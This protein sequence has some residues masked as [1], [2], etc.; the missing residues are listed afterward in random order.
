MTVVGWLVVALV[1]YLAAVLLRLRALARRRRLAEAD[2]LAV[3]DL[4]W[5]AHDALV[6]TL[7][8][9]IRGDFLPRPEP[10]GSE[11]WRFYEARAA[12]TAAQQA[13]RWTEPTAGILVLPDGM[14]G[15]VASVVPEGQAKA[16]AVL[17]VAR[18]HVDQV[19]RYA[20]QVI[21]HP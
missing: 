13:G 10:A 11:M 9:S 17:R 3:R 8:D 21:H 16:T 4:D 5:S 7:P 12:L 18:G 15:R 6:A 19:R 2:A 1:V 20:G 14:G